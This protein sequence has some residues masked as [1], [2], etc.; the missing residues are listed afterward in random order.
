MFGHDILHHGPVSWFSPLIFC[1]LPV[2]YG[3]GAIFIITGTVSLLALAPFWWLVL[4]SRRRAARP[5]HPA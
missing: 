3:V 5:V 4:R 2:M 1:T